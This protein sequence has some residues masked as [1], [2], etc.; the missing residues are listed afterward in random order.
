MN[1][2][3]I[4]F[5]NNIYVNLCIYS[6]WCVLYT[7]C[8][9]YV[10]DIGFS[11]SC[12]FLSVTGISVCLHA[13]GRSRKL[14]HQHYRA[15]RTMQNG[16]YS[17]SLWMTKYC[18]PAICHEITENYHGSNTVFLVGM[19]MSVVGGVFVVFALMALCYRSVVVH[20]NF[21][22]CLRLVCR[23]LHVEFLSLSIYLFSLYVLCFF[24]LII[25]VYYYYSN[26]FIIT[27]LYL[28][29][30]YIYMKTYIIFIHIIYYII[31]F[32][33]SLS[34]PQLRYSLSLYVIKFYNYFILHIYVYDTINTREAP[35]I[36]LFVNI[37]RT[38]AN[39]P[40]Y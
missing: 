24:I 18:C 28:H 23:Y 8:K 22:L 13:V 12:L 20:R 10:A 30:Q 34:F 25:I 27:I 37:A 31:H 35:L 21:S 19:L 26:S 3:I 1:P 7:Y 39:D 40:R 4:I 2:N 33:S 11:V 17:T 6:Q 5:I 36:A 14:N 16:T 29:I 38:P 9:L 15:L 32:Y